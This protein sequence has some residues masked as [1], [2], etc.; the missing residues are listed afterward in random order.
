MHDMLCMVGIIIVKK[1]GFNKI[2]KHAL[3]IVILLDSSGNVMHQ[4]VMT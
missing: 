1:N 3:C 2:V 4:F